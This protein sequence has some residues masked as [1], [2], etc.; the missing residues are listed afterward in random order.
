MATE[1]VMDTKE[2]ADAIAWQASHA[3]ENGAPCT[4]RVIRALEQVAKTDTAT[5]RRIAN[6][7]GLSLKDAMPLR[8]AGGLHSL[9]LTGADNRLARVYAGQI[10]EQTLVDELVCELV[11]TFDA[12]LLPWLDGPPQ[13]N[14]AGRSASIMAGLMWLAGKL[15]PRF[16]LNELGASAG[17][18]TM[19]DR[20]RYDLGGVAA[21]PEG[22]PMLIRPVWRGTPPPDN[23]VEIVAIQ[24]CDQAPVD[25]TNPDYALKLKSYVWPDAQER[26]GRIDAAIELAQ[27][28]PPQ[29]AHLDAGDFV[30]RILK[31]PQNGGVTR[32]LY[33]S[34][35]WQYIPDETQAGITHAMEQAGEMATRERPLAW[36]KLETNRE[37][38]RHELRVQYW[39]G[40]E[41]EALL[42]CAHPHGAW[43]EWLAE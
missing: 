12:Q 5:G 6:W 31:L 23:P 41:E 19:M 26:M 40:G 15:G 43:V 38:F 11:E 20:Y 16:E 2:L 22:S 3:E 9:V 21:G 37:T 36:V 30:T 39:P 25:L 17:V 42:G 33:H 10:T 24:G 8:I 28:A 35:V 4:A 7:Q 32:V 18:N 27:Q 29:V 14:E 34:I 13:T 1:G